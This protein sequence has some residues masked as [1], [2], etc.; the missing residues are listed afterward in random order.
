MKLTSLLIALIILFLQS[1]EFKTE[2]K[3]KGGDEKD[4]LNS[5]TSRSKVRNN[6]QLNSK[7]VKVAQ[8]YLYFEDGSLVPKSNQVNVNQKVKM[9]LVIEDGWKEENGKVSIGASEKVE[10]NT[11]KEVLNVE[12]LFASVG[13]LEPTDSKFIILSVVITGLDQLYDHFL[14]SFRVWDKN[15]AGEIT[16]N[17]KLYLKQE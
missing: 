11:G 10:T 16:G 6:I 9:R 4:N 5:S 1:C 7:G 13:D 17:Y 2:I 15:G 3:R 8:A 14:V 12:D